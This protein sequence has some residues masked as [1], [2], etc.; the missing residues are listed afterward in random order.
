MRPALNKAYAH[1]TEA[2]TGLAANALADRL[3][4]GMGFDPLDLASMIAPQLPLGMDGLRNDGPLF[5]VPAAPLLPTL[6]INLPAALPLPAPVAE[7]ATSGVATVSSDGTRQRVRVQ[8]AVSDDLANAL[9]AGQ[10]GKQ[11]EHV[12]QQIE[13]HNAL[14]SAAEAPVNRGV[15]FASLPRLCYRLPAGEGQQG[16]LVLLER[17]A[18]FDQVDLN[19]LCQT[20]SLPG[21]SMVEQARAWEVYLDG[22][23]LRVGRGDSAQLALDAVRGTITEDDLVR[24]LSAELQHPTRNAARDVLPVHL[25]AFVMATVRHLVHDQHIPVEQLARHQYALVQRLAARIVELRDE[26]SR[27]AF[28][29]CVLDRG[30][31]LDASVTNVFKFEAYPVSGNKR[32]RGKFRFAKHYY[33]VLANLKD[34]GEEWRCAMAIDQHPKVRHWVRNID[35]DPTFG[36]WLPTSFGRFY[37]DFVCEL[38][39]GSQLVIEYKGAQIRDMPKE[40]EKAQ[41]GKL[42]AESSHGRC[43]FAFIYL[44]EGGMNMAQQLDA[45]LA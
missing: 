20:I 43:R 13:R 32:Y 27:T 23:K 31:V 17:E 6:T 14:V 16:E 45:A 26:A 15:P 21:F 44:Q 9:V 11:R 19:L 35:S 5:A 25:R 30:W 2:E 40:I 36:F 33:P 1:V 4:D 24:W 29:Q 42:W 18:V 12:Q 34:G 28:R 39:D 41:V 8:G 38:M 3:I 37:P 10:R 22:Q 7:A